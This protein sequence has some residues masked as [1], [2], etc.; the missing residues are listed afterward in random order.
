MNSR[1]LER[2]DLRPNPRARSIN[3]NRIGEALEMME[4]PIKALFVYCSNPLVVAPDVERVRRGF[5]REDLFTVVHD[6][7]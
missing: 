2:P 7:F 1:A 4:Q 5:A 6:L 3:M